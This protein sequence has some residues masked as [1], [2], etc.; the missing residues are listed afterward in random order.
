MDGQH[1][2]T[3]GPK[4]IWVFFSQVG[5]TTLAIQSQME[6]QNLQEIAKIIKQ[7][8]TAYSRCVLERALSHISALYKSCRFASLSATLSLRTSIS[9]CRARTEGKSLQAHYTV[10]SKKNKK[11]LFFQCS[12]AASFRNITLP[13]PFHATAKVCLGLTTLGC[14][15]EH[16]PGP[17]SLFANPVKHHSV[18]VRPST[19]QQ[20]RLRQHCTHP[21]SN[22]LECRS[23]APLHLS[24]AAKI[25]RGAHD[26]GVCTSHYPSRT[27][28]T[29]WLQISKCVVCVCAGQRS[30]SAGC[31][32]GS[33]AVY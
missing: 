29:G 18:E 11:K 22:L 10:T 33:H 1:H 17:Y 7:T 9:E 5:K 32:R 26:I 21:C 25:S 24:L 13:C 8:L 6:R 30:R 28:N 3:E 31:N 14:R 23:K 15:I 20:Q 16:I 4:R 19:Q 12:A 2:E 27:Q